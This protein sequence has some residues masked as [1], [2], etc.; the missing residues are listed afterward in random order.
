M[1]KKEHLKRL[2]RGIKLWNS[3]RDDNLEVKIDLTD[4]NLTGA[5]L[6]EADLTRAI[7]DQADLTGANL[8]DANLRNSHL[9]TADLT[10]ADLT[11]ADLTDADLRN[12]DL[13]KANLSGANL[14]GAKLARANLTEAK[15]SKAIIDE[16]THYKKIKGC[17]IG[18]NGIWCKDTD[19]AALRVLTPPGNSMQAS[20]PDAVIESLK[21]ARRL[22]GFSMTLA[23]IFILITMLGIDE[24]II[25]FSNLEI[26]PEKF[27][28]FAMFISIGVLSLVASFMSDALKG[29]RYLRERKSAMVVGNFPWVLSKYSG[30]NWANKI[31]SFFT[32]IIMSFHVLV[33]LFVLL[34][35]D[36]WEVIDGWIFTSGM[37]LLLMFTVWIFIISQQFQKPILCDKQTEKMHQTDIE[38]LTVAIREQTDK[39]E[40]LFESVKPQI[41]ENTSKNL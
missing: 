26:P 14:S 33:Y 29:T 23:A 4:A 20:L 34:S 11:E 41:D 27:G 38:K 15:L 16:Y 35:W 25:I 13:T 2:E 30:S 31:L 1:R 22:H 10:E 36:K 12:A 5:N 28:L 3:W 32:R 8:T 37:L 39:I 40:K 24:P 17:Q 6:I 21:H 9:T 7:L 18:V 19:S